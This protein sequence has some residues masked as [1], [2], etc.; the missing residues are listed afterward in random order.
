M[1]AW[2]WFL[3]HGDKVLGLGTTILTVLAAAG[4]VSNPISAAVLA[5]LT[6]IHTTFLPEASDA[7]L[8]AP[9]AEAVAK[10]PWIVSVLAIALG[11]AGCASLEAGVNSPVGQA[12]VTAGVQ[13]AVTTAEQHGVSAVQ[14]NS[15]S[16]AILADTQ[17]V[18]STL[19]GLTQVL[20]RELVKL[21]V[22]Q[23]DIQ[24]FQGLEIAFDVYLSAKYG[25]NPTIAEVQQ[26][27]GAW[28]N[29]AIADT[30]G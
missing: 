12:A 29:L 3:A 5:T 10:L 11:L 16:K 26:D 8:P 13:V 22:P 2:N 21:K 15:V 9:V 14:I 23:A 30:G 6:F 25:A 4:V 27:L 19:S 24:A 18:S 1:K 7:P 28:L 17:G 20:D